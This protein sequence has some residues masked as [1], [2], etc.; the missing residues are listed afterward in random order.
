MIVSPSR[1]VTRGRSGPFRAL[2]SVGCAF[3]AIGCGPDV[4]RPDRP[5]E[6]PRSNAAEAVPS[7]EARAAVA[8]AEAL[9]AGISSGDTSALAA[10]LLPESRLV[11]VADDTSQP[12]RISESQTFL[13]Q[14]GGATTSFLERMWDPVVHVDG[15]IATVWTPYDFHRG[16]EFSHCGIDAFHLVR[17]PEGWKVLSV[18]YSMHREQDCEPSP[19][20]NAEPGP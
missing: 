11:A 16:G 1:L 6:A 20:G 17:R 13:R 10:V 12:L 8:A 4:D 3:Y 9:L 19:L 15:P 7:G 5:A 2:L 18:M 14:V